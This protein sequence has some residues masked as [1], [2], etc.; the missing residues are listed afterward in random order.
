MT[1][2]ILD[3]IVLMSCGFDGCLDLMR[4]AVVSKTVAIGFNPA[5]FMVSPDSLHQNIS[6]RRQ[7]MQRKRTAY[8]QDPRFRLPHLKHKPPRHYRQRT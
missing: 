7:C 2:R 8:Q 3:S 6:Q 1:P 4:I 5:A